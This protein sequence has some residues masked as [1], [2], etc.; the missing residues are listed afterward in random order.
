MLNS[1]ALMNGLTQKMDY[2][3]V[4]QRVLS[5]NITNS[6]SSGYQAKDVAAPDF[7][8]TMGRYI[9]AS[10]VNG[11]AKLS[12]ATTTEGQVSHLQMLNRADTGET[13]RQPFEVTP[14]KNGVNLEDQ[15]M[16]ASQTAID[17]QLITNIYNKNLGLIRSAIKG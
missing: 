9:N 17:Y 6:D 10:Q 15:M 13:E 1:I 8:K 14:I 5:Q 4:R 3:Q 7:K 2:L 12:L 11:G 16:K